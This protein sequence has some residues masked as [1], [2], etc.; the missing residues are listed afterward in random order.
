M[1]SKSVDPTPLT[2]I[3]KSNMMTENEGRTSDPEEYE[4]DDFE[5][6]DMV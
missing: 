1:H 4:N 6:D 3:G 2:K 5:K